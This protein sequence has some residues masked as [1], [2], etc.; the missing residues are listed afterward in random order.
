MQRRA[1]C[2]AGV[3][4]PWNA[5]RPN[6]WRPYAGQYTVCDGPDERWR[7][8]WWVNMGSAL[9]TERPY[10]LSCSSRPRRSIQAVSSWPRRVAWRGVRST[11]S[12]FASSSACRSERMRVTSSSLAAGGLLSNVQVGRMATHPF[13]TFATTW[14][15][16]RGVVF[17]FSQQ[18]D[19]RGV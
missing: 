11:E 5:Y 12:L 18:R 15:L 4:A 10:T 19:G 16:G 7:R 8:T 1:S 6:V 2:E 3:V 17:M 9:S 13:L 14:R